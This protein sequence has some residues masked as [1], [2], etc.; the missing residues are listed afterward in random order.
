VIG[1]EEF[2]GREGLE[3]E[4][5]QEKRLTELEKE[6]LEGEVVMEELEKSLQK[7]NNNTSSGWDGIGYG[8]LKKYWEYIKEAML[9]MVRETFLKGDLTS[10]F[11]LG[12]IRLLPKKQDSSK[13][14]DWRPITLLSCG[15]KVLS[16]VVANRL[17]KTLLRIIGRAQKGF[18]KQKNIHTST[19]NIIE[20]IGRSWTNREE[21]GVLCVDFNKAFDSIGHEYIRAVLKFFNFGETMIKMVSTC[22]TGRVSR[23]ILDQGYSKD[24][25]IEFGTPQGDKLSPYIFILA[26]EILLIKIRLLDGNGIDSCEFMTERLRNRIWENMTSE[27]FADDL[28]LMFKMSE[29]AIRTIIKTLDEF[30]LVSGLETNKDKTQLMVCGGENWMTGQK[31]LGIAVVEK[32]KI[33]GIEIDRKIEKLSENWDTVAKKM[34]NQVK[35]WKMFGLSITRRVMVAKTYLITQANYMLQ[36]LPLRKEEGDRLNIII[37]EFVKGKDR[38]LARDRKLKRRE[39]GGYGIIDMNEMNVSLKANWIKKWIGEREVPDFPRERVLKGGERSVE[40][41]S[42]EDIDMGMFRITG[43]IVGQW[44]KVKEKFYDIGNNITGARIFENAGIRQG[45]GKLEN[46]IFGI[47][48]YEEIRGN[49]RNIRIEDIASGEGMVKD[50]NIVE[51]TLGIA[52]NMAEYFRLREKI[53]E[54]VTR[55]KGEGETKF[56]LEELMGRKRKGSRIFREIISGRISKEHRVYKSREITPIRTYWGEIEEEEEELVRMNLDIWGIGKLEAPLKE[57]IFKLLNGQVWL[58]AQLGHFTDIG[59]Q[60]TFCKIK[61][62]RKLQE[63]GIREDDGEYI[64]RINRLERETIKHILGNCDATKE[65]VKKVLNNIAGKEDRPLEVNTKQF[66]RG[67]LGNSISESKIS[68]LIPYIIKWGIIKAKKNGKLPNKDLILMDI[69]YTMERLGRNRELKIG[70]R[71]IIELSDAYLYQL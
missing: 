23:I 28:T 12:L 1:I 26:I 62:R 20:N 37:L 49:V 57:F 15:Y 66:T 5:V 32:V 9:G 55:K 40:Q 54:V 4:W 30:K 46:Y 53:R 61:E 3:K 56:Y 45:E 27:C 10:T 59:P 44:D 31:I 68:V 60:C 8:V 19:I 69:K 41:L 71:N 11:K 38:E 29:R 34:V 25:K 67:R 50:K 24:I 33:V 63:E 36:V 21:M 18:M 51:R 6:G 2:I 22:L 52:L 17:E 58:N 43:D 42:I 65:V 48:R 47:E 7:C 14:K 39:L 70:V 35:F 64:R 13:I 16:G